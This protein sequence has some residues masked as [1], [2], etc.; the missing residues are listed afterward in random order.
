MLRLDRNFPT[1]RF[2]KQKEAKWYKETER[3]VCPA[4]SKMV[5]SAANYTPAGE[6]TRLESCVEKQVDGVQRWTWLSGLEPSKL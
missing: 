5:S 3:S 6:E 1:D 4:A 2:H